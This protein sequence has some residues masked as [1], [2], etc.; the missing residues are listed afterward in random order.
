MQTVSTKDQA[1][2]GTL[3][4]SIQSNHAAYPDIMEIVKH[5]CVIQVKSAAGNLRKRHNLNRSKV[6]SACCAEYKSRCGVEHSSRLPQEIASL[7]EAGIDSFQNGL[8]KGLFRADNTI[9][10]NSRAVHKAKDSDY[11]MRHTLI[12]EDQMALTDK[13][14]VCQWDIG[15]AERRLKTLRDKFSEDNIA[16]TNCL[17]SI[18]SLCKTHDYLEACLAGV[19]K[20]NKTP[21]PLPTIN[22]AQ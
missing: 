14:M 19:V 3:T 8:V 1:I 10:C 16:I 6:F 13:V 2:S 15:Q 5:N 11:V 20:A 9:S 18:A 12:A 21:M 7:I 4:D 22:P 17:K